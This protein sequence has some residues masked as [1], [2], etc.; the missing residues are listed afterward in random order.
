LGVEEDHPTKT[1]TPAVEEDLSSYIDPF[2][3]SIANTIAPGKAEL[4][5]LETELVGSVDVL[6]T[7]N[8]CEFQGEFNNKSTYLNGLKIS[9]S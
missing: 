6:Q 3:T 7:F 4:K 5:Y 1:L 8:P 9:C 2:D